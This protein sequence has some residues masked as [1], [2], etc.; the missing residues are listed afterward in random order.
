MK[1]IGIIGGLGPEATVEYYNGI[2]NS[3]KTEKADLVYPEIIIYSVNMSVFI[4]LMKEKHYDKAVDEVISKLVSLQKAGADFA[5]ITAN[6]PHM[7]FSEISERSPLPLISIVEVTRDECL[8][9]G[10]RK[11]GLFGTGF[12]MNSTFYQDV[13]NKSGI[14]VILP[15]EGDRNVINTKLFSEIEIGI[16]RDDT[17]QTLIGIMEK[18]KAEHD[19][20]SLILGCTELPLILT[21]PEYAGMPMLNTTM[22]HVGAIVR[23]CIEQNSL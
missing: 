16:F 14:E 22:L 20:D 18:M 23:K 1:K 21:Q 9:K 12:T 17:R 3:F 8:R 13:F 7:L 19:I 2:I 10:Y 5:A 6:T 11:T 15:D 4:G